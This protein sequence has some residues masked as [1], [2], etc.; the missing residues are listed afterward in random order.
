MAIPELK[1]WATMA[2]SWS[3][4]A[5]GAWEPVLAALDLGTNNCRLLVARPQADGFE[6]VDSNG[7]EHYVPAKRIPVVRRDGNAWNLVDLKEGATVTTVEQ[8]P[9]ETPPEGAA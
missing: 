1:L 6:V 5:G 2:A 7:N 4:H 9:A 3:N 8:I